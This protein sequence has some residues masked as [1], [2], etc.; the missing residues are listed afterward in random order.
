MALAPLAHVLWTR[1]MQ[2]DASAPDWPDRDRFVLSNGHA[3]II[4]YTM[5]YLTGYGVELDD[6]R[7]LRQWG[8]RTPGHPEYRRLKGVEVTT[9]PLGQG[10]ANGVGMGLAEGNLRSRFGPEV[11][12]HHV[13]VVCGDGCLEEGVSHESA[14]LAGHL[15]I[16]RLVYIY[17]DNH[18]SI[19]GPTELA[20][21]DDVP[22]RFAGYGWHVVELGEVANDVDAIEAGIREGMAEAERPSIVILRSHIGWPSPKYTDTAF[23]HGNALGAD[24]VAAVKDILG[25]PQEDFYSPADVMQY[26]RDGGCA[27]RDRANR[28]GTSPSRVPRPRAESQRRVRRVP[29]AARA[30]GLG[31]EAAHVERGRHDRHPSRVRQDPRSDRRRG[32]GAPR[33]WRRSEREHRHVARRCP[34]DLRAPPRR[35]STALRRPRARHGLDHERHVGERHRPRGRHVLRVQRLH[36]P[37]RPTGRVVAVQDRVRVD[38]RLGWRG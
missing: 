18:I 28:L 32:T 12:D 6:L 23:A 15:G 27:R 4:L 16:G 31:S 25:L 29:R 36:A 1:I 9:G 7:S 37:R 11:T 3:S 14:S 30:P 20:Y 5:L 38:A 10:F 24:E 35:T 19:D 33:G 34:G 17:D 21:S 26:Y 13:F 22:K 8:S 2:Y